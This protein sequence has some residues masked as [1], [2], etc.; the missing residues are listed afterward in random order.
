MALLKRKGKLLGERGELQRGNQIRSF[1]TRQK[2]SGGRET[3]HGD[4]AYSPKRGG[5]NW[6]VG[7]PRGGGKSKGNLGI[8]A[9]DN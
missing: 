4:K 5:N 8:Q 6:G 9:G 1:H 2:K 7:P 3:A